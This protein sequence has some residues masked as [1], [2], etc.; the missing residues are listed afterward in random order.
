MSAPIPPCTNGP[1]H[2]WAWAKNITNAQIGGRSA[3]F[4]L[5]GLYRCACG[6]KKVGAP[7]H[8]G[9]DLRGI[10]G[11]DIFMASATVAPSKEGS[12]T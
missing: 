1:R 11:S 8:D 3:K 9:P 4:S 10:V 7:N 5:R 12:A 2:T 6:A